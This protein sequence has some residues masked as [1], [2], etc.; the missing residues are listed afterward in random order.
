M[1]AFIAWVHRRLITD[2]TISVQTTIRPD[3]FCDT[4]ICFQN[5]PSTK[6]EDSRKKVESEKRKT[7]I[8]AQ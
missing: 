1:F 4:N 7:E 2:S 5:I 3:F 6:R 8:T